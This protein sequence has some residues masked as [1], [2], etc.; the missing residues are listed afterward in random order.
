MPLFGNCYEVDLSQVSRSSES[1]WYGLRFTIV[2]HEGN[3]QTQTITPAFK[4][5]DQSGL[6]IHMPTMLSHPDVRVVG[7][8]IYA[9]EGSRIYNLTGEATDGVNVESGVYI[10]RSEGGCLKVLVR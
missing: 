7:H 8:N 10:I 4:I 1:K 2:D 3:S 5:E 9:P 6:G